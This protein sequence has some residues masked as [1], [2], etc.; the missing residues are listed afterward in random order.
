MSNDAWWQ[1]VEDTIR[2]R[3]LM[4]HP[5]NQAWRDGRLKLEDVQFYGKQ[6]FRHVDAFPRYVSATHCNTDDIRVRQMLLSNLVEEEQGSENHPELFLRFCEGAGLDRDE[7][8]S[9]DIRP[10]TKECV[11]T[12]MK[13]AKNSNH[14]AG[15]AALYAYE[16]Q[17]H[18]LSESKVQR[19]DVHYGIIDERAYDFFKV[20]IEADVYHS[21]AEAN[22]IQAAAQTDE[23]RQLVL[24]SVKEACDAVWGLFDGIAKHCGTQMAA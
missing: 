24:E 2:S 21:A 15:L 13:L 22:A 17:Q 20:H 7:V 5:F 8:E 19:L 18:E 12:F 11:D 4:D 9:A 1:E 6:Y 3:F 14:L 23:D 16:S 10:E